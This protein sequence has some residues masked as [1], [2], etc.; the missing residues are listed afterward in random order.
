MIS[1]VGSWHANLLRIDRRKCVLF[2]HDMTLFSLF[3]AGLK[4]PDFEHIPTGHKFRLSRQAAQLSY[5]DQ[6]FGQ[7]MFRSLRLFDFEQTQIERMLDWSQQNTYAK[8]N[9]RSVMG[10]MNDMAFHIEHH[11]AHEGGL[12]YADLDRL[13][14]RI[15]EIPFKAIG[16]EYPRVR[17]QTLL[18]TDGTA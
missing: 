6:L 4:R 18:R 10:S 14:L 13:L 17:L 9:N 16:Y 1:D 2:T 11:I 7:A 3:V 15:N 8:T 5:I 12:A